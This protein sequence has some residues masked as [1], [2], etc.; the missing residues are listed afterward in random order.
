MSTFENLT[1]ATETYENLTLHFV[2]HNILPI[3]ILCNCIRTLTRSKIVVNRMVVFLCVYRYW[4]LPEA[5]RIIISEVYWGQYSQYC[6][7]G[8]CARNTTIIEIDL[9]L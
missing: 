7:F 6:K 1:A 4:K 8:N 9:F 2:W 3:S 5:N